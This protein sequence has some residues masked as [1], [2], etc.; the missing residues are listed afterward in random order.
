DIVAHN[1]ETVERLT[2]SVRS[3]ATYQK[4]LSVIAHIA[5][6][7]YLAKSGIMVGLGETPEEVEQALSH[8]AGVGCKAVTIGQYLQP[9]GN[10][11]PVVEYVTPETFDKYKAKAVE[12]GFRF[13]E[14]G[15]LVRSSYHAEE[16][17]KQSE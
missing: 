4:S 12:L 16:S 8:L 7:G 1:L 5:K 13:V 14:S 9:R 15:P 3:R 10:N 11:L 6:N 2:P 17:A